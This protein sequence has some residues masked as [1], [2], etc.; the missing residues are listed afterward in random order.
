MEEKFH[1]KLKQARNLSK[2][3]PAARKNIQDKMK[4]LSL[5]LYTEVMDM[6][7]LGVALSIALLKDILDFVGIGSLPAIGTVVTVIA[8]ALITAS[9]FIISMGSGVKTGKKAQKNLKANAYLM[10]QAG[11][12][13]GGT[14]IEVIFGLDFLP[15]E[16]IMAVAMYRLILKARQEKAQAAEMSD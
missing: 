15:I 3:I 2:K 16:T 5:F 4:T 10:K 8:S 13:L 9:M 11:T 12:L 7:F 14:T 6:P 1:Q